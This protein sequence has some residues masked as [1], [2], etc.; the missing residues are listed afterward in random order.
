M[1]TVGQES[2]T[3]NSQGSEQNLLSLSFGRIVRKDINTADGLLPASFETYQIVEP[4]DVVFRFTDLQNDK[5]SLRSA[6]VVERGIIT[7]A[8]L[9][10][11]PTGIDPRFFEYLMRGY[12]VSKVFYGMGGGLRQSL[13]YD[14]VRR[15]PV[16]VPPL[17]EQ[18]A[19]T[20]YLDRE[21][22]QI[23]ELIEKQTTLID[24][25]QERRYA[26]ISSVA[27]LDNRAADPFPT[28]GWS[29]AQEGMSVVPLRAL[30]ARRVTDGPHE[31]PEFLDDGVPFLSVDGI[32][33]GELVFDGRTRY[34]SEEDHRRFSLKAK[35]QRG[36]VL[37]GKAASTGKIAEVK[38]DTEFNVW[39]P[40]AILRPKVG[41]S[42][43]WLTYALKAHSSQ[44]QIDLL[45]T[46]NTQKNIAMADIPRVMLAV[47][48]LAH[49]DAIVKHLD[50]ET[51]KIDEL[52]G[53]AERFIELTRERRSALITAAVTGQ[54]DVAT[55][56]GVA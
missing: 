19:I 38:V 34:I 29:T 24:R 48:D 32:Q 53:T 21:T 11:T 1:F 18:H 36:D 3:K 28:G 6:R 46:N 35:P 31:T 10:F 14:D 13:K 30:L 43:A 33:D 16:L 27:G 2:T 51:A 8:Y 9:A 41:V 49:Q 39:S 20:D 23:D 56:L 54:L 47:P 15:M 7:S 12:D 37:M 17:S 25:L 22:A 55:R 42:S 5:R 45:C 44:V 26:L 40:L 50:R 4:D 52:L